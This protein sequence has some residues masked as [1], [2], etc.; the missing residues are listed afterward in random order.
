MYPV[1]PGRLLK[2]CAKNEE[3]ALLSYQSENAIPLRNV[4]ERHAKEIER[5]ELHDHQSCAVRLQVPPQ[6]IFGSSL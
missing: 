4:R 5:F 2:D 1:I 3:R 6:I